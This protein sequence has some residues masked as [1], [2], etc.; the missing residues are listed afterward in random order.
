MPKTYVVTGATGLV[1]RTLVENLQGRGDRVIIFSRD[2]DRAR[3]KVPGCA[4]YVRWNAEPTPGAWASALQDVDG[5]VHLAGAPVF[6]TRW[7]PDYKAQI[8]A[9]RWEGTLG[10][11]KALTRGVFV[12]ASAIG[13]YGF[14]D[15]TPL[16][17]DAPAGQDFLAQV[18]VGWEKAARQA[19]V[20][21]VILRFGIILDREEGALAQMLPPFQNFVGGPLGSGNQWFSWVHLQDA[22]GAIL[23]A[24]DQPSLAGTFNCTAPESV[25][26]A[27]FSRSLGQ[28]IQRPSWAPVPQF[29]LELMVGEAAVILVEGQLVIPDKLV[30][31]GYRFGFPKVGQALGDLLGIS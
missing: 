31:A 27:D 18:C 16:A 6:G 3:S 30:K 2:P 24:L 11:A 5:L 7:T 9:S 10:L 1:G 12:S 25:T 26:N 19:S 14:R 29:V 4:D 21:T 8:Q 20:R 23:F 28:T 13:Y 22:V 17:E 15:G